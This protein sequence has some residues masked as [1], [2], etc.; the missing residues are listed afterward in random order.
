MIATLPDWIGYAAV[1]VWIALMI[2]Y[3]VYE[4]RTPG[5]TAFTWHSSERI[6][7]AIFW[8]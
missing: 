4:A 2:A 6:R 8:P 7:E 5:I 1:V 3:T